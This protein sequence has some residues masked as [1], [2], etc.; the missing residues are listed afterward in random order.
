MQREMPVAAPQVASLPVAEPLSVE[1]VRRFT[2]TERSVHWVQAASFLLLLLTGFA[3]S[4]QPIEAVF[5]HRALLREM[6]LSSAFFFFFGPAVVA[7]AGDRRSVAED[8]EAVDTW[9]ADDLRWLIPSPLLG[10]FGLPTPRPGRFNAGQKLNA[11]FVAWSVLTFTVTGLI[12]WQNRRFPSDLVSRSNDIHTLLAYLAFGAFLGHLYLATG[13]PK[14]R[15]S[16]RGMTLGWV[17]VDWARE[18][19]P[20]WLE[21]VSAPPAAPRYDALRTAAQIV[22]GGLVALF[23]SRILFFALGA[24]TT[25]W[26]TDKLY[27]VTAWPRVASVVPVTGVRV[28]DWP[29]VGYLLLLVIA[30]LAAD[31]M[32]QVPGEQPGQK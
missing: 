8:V 12:I 6:H 13:D 21:R 32:R 30:W 1:R 2:R 31:R 19:H 9:D 22:L 4:L 11:I 23:A 24:N 17:R 20:R 3:L 15:P 5:G 27:A 18:H 14:T 25:D 28:A 16:L 26:V 7:L 10:L 29:A